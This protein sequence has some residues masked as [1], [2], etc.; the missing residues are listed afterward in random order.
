[1]SRPRPRRRRE[2]LKEFIAVTGYHERS[3]IR[4]LNSP[5]PS[6]R[7]RRRHRASLYDEAVRAAL[8][9]LSE[10]SDRVCGKRLKARIPI[11]LPALG[12]NGHLTLDEHI[13]PKILSMTAATVDRFTD[14]PPSGSYEEAQTG[15]TRAAAAHQDAHV[16]G[17]E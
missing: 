3:T 11:L 12:R 10:A 16:C 6:K 2:I 13:R 4:V 15:G 8:I 7:R 1:M 17:L 14:D 9:V 5:G